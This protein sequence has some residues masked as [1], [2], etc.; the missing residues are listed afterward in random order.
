MGIQTRSTRTIHSTGYYSSNHVLVNRERTSRGLAPLRRCV[1][2]D[3]LARKHAE[4]MA[5][6]ERVLPS[7][8]TV[9]QLQEK[10]QSLRVGE[11]TV[12]GESIRDIHR[13]MMTKTK[14]RH[15]R[16][17]VLAPAFNSFGMGTAMGA[18]GKLYLVQL[19]CL[20]EEQDSGLD[21]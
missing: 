13:E 17:N 16:G 2:L 5:Q 21:C 3:Q 15:C 7:V 14:Q 10:L 9:A 20:E 1:R 19:F 4:S 8:S 11:N 6:S 12:R 18:D